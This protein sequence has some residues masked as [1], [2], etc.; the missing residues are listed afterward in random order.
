MTSQNFTKTMTSFT[1]SP[2]DVTQCFEYYCMPSYWSTKHQSR[3]DVISHFVAK[4]IEGGKIVV[5]QTE[6]RCELDVS[7]GEDDGAK[8][9]FFYPRGSHNDGKM[10]DGV[11]IFVFIHG[12]YWEEGSRSFYHGLAKPYL[13]QNVIVAFIGYDLC[14]DSHKVPNIERQCV[15]ALTFLA[16]KYPK[17]RLVLS[18]HSAGAYLAVAMLSYQQLVPRFHALVL[19]CGVYELGDLMNTH[20]R[21][22]IDVSRLD[23]QNLLQR[24]FAHVS[25]NKNDNVGV[26]GDKKNAQDSQQEVIETISRNTITNNSGDTQFKILK[27][28][29]YIGGSESPM[30]HYQS[31]RMY[32]KLSRDGF[33]VT[34]NA[35]KGE[36]HFSLIEGMLDKDSV[37][38]QS[39]F[40]LLW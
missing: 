32:E 10:L 38:T 34:F 16:D 26:V 18:G 6:S 2:S 22:A 37:V 28:L 33:D 25:I 19:L 17:S 4:M 14:S 11:P 13:D 8:I 20:I 35:L 21:K 29:M 27:I 40:G 30:F 23:E 3:D 24:Q 31:A 12:G 1:S 15:K 7:Y 39:I 9:D 36:D 5:G